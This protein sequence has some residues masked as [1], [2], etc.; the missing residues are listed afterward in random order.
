[1]PPLAGAPP[2]QNNNG[3]PLVATDFRLRHDMIQQVQNTCQFHGLPGDDANRHIDKFL[4]V[5]QHMKQNGVSD[6]ALHLSLFPYFLTHYATACGVAYDGPMIPPTPSPLPKEVKREIDATKDKPTSKPSIPYPLRLNNQ[7]LCE[8]ANNQMLKFLQIFQRLHFDISFADALLHMPKFASTFKS[9]LSNKEKLFEL[10]NP[11]SNLL[12]MNNEYIKQVDGTMMKFSIEESPELELKDLPSHLESAFLEGSDKLPVII[13][14]ELKD[15]E[16]TAILK[17]LKSHKR[18]IVWKI[19]DIHDL[20]PRF[21]THKI[22]MED[23]F[24]LAVQHQNRVNPKIHK[25]L[26]ADHLSRLE[27]PH[28]GDLE[29]KEINET[30]P[31]KTLGMISFHAIDILTACHNGPTKGHHGAN[32]TAKKIFDS[33]FYWLT[34]YRDAHEMVKSCDSCQRQGK[35]SQK[36]EMPQN[37]IQVCEIFDIWSIDFMVPFMYSR[38]NK[39]ILVVVDYLSKWV[40]VKALPTNDARVVVKFL[41]SLFARFGTPRAIFSDRG[42]Y[43][44]NDQF[45]KVMLKY[46]VT[47]HLSTTYHSQ[48]S[49][50]VEVLNRGLKC[51]LERTVGDHQKVQMNELKELCDQPY[52]NSL[53]YKVKTKKIHDSK[54]KNRVFNVEY[55]CRIDQDP[56]FELLV[57][58]PAACQSRMLPLCFPTKGMRLILPNSCV[59]WLSMCTWCRPIRKEGCA[60][61]DGGNCTWGGQARVFGTVSVCASVQEMAGGEGRVLAGRF[62]EGTMA[63]VRV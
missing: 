63:L 15:E 27:N 16:K 53:I 44:Y 41:K 21:C 9:L 57:W 23:D 1:G 36:D 22:L 61:W 40:E 33:D 31:L 47:N 17:I 37:A 20:Y 19:S 42:T 14:K 29:K 30:F 5:T 43:F 46:G 26:A 10:E 32:Y 60:T 55:S 7:K 13:S 6:D 54:I 45:A 56:S 18:A 8:N 38:G 2:P 34:I 11:S 58:I 59:R 24:K 3:L 39:Y 28:E 62:V 52:E 4:E 50:Q 25:N 51:I 35:I 49:R 48:T 12:M